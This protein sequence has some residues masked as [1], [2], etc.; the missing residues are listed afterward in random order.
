[1]IDDKS[2]KPVLQSDSWMVYLYDVRHARN[3]NGDPRNLRPI[4]V[5]RCE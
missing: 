4:L 5:Q 2:G 1:M 3:V